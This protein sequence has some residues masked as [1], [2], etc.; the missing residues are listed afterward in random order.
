M[1][2]SCSAW[3]QMITIEID[4]NNLNR[5]AINLILFYMFSVNPHVSI[6]IYSMLFAKISLFSFVGQ[7]NEPLYVR[8]RFID[9]A[10]MSVA[11]ALWCNS[12][13]TAAHAITSICVDSFDPSESAS[14]ANEEERQ[15]RNMG[16]FYRFLGRTS[17]KRFSW[18]NLPSI[19]ISALLIYSCR[20]SNAH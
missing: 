6:Y 13:S 14:W 9:F 1:L 19:N 11:D 7:L 18:V 16:Y 8:L 2:R 17:S 3:F 5:C 12:I 20:L 15:P 4:W 10:V